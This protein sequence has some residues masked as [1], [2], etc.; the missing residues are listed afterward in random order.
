[1]QEGSAEHT[2][3][4]IQADYIPTTEEVIPLESNET[5]ITPVEQPIELVE[6][7]QAEYIPTNDIRAAEHDEVAEDSI[8][9]LEQVA[10]QTDH[11]PTIEEVILPETNDT[12]N[13][14][15][16]SDASAPLYEQITP[17]ERIE[18]EEPTTTP[19][20]EEMD[21]FSPSTTTSVPAEQVVT[22]ETSQQS[23]L[24]STR[25]RQKRSFLRRLITAFLGI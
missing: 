19:T 25:P 23:S 8:V 22:P 11:V 3:S 2:P 7:V 21:A 10:M 15:D 12:T 6:F 18:V 17:A 14:N 24:Q 16:I 13:T 4:P 5:G 1:M 9:P 20:D